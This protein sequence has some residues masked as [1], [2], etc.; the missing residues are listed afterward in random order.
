MTLTYLVLVL[1]T[2]P[3]SQNGLALISCRCVIQ[4]LPF[5]P[6]VLRALAR[7]LDDKKRLVRREAVQARGEW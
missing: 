6:R 3:V 7:P 1:R 2:E 4:V 5:R